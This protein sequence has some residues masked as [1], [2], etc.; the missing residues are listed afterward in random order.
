MW[1]KEKAL[2][3]VSPDLLFRGGSYSS[4]EI[5]PRLS[6]WVQEF[7]LPAAP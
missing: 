1:V 7:V 3:G 6:G 2:G 4:R 5:S